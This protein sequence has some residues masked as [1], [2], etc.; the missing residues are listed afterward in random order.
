LRSSLMIPIPA[1]AQSRSPATIE[2][3]VNS[4]ENVTSDA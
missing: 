3:T 1:V 4:Q 2:S